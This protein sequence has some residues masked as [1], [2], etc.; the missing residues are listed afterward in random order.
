MSFSVNSFNVTASA[1]NIWNRVQRIRS[2]LLIAKTEFEGS[3]GDASR[4]VGLQKFMIEFS[5]EVQLAS[6]ANKLGV[7]ASYISNNLATSNIT[8]PQINGLHGEVDALTTELSNN[9][10][11]MSW[12]YDSGGDYVFLPPSGATEKQNIIDAIDD[13]LTRTGD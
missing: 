4:L 12:S 13:I 9:S 2:Q 11:N 6:N 10:T 5:A 3:P 7:V 8:L 1:N